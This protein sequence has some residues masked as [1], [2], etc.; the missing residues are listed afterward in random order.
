M[1]I[2]FNNEKETKIPKN[3]AKKNKVNKINDFFLRE[4]ILNVF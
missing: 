2:V 3:R 1:K 4:K